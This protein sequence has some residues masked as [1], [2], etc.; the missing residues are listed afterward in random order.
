MKWIMADE[1]EE[2]YEDE[3]VDDIDDRQVCR[4]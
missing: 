3:L 2:D 1:V 4:C